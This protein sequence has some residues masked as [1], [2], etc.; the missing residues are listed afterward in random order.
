M[1][2][3]NLDVLPLVLCL[4]PVLIFSII[5]SADPLIN[6]PVNLPKSLSATLGE[7]R[8]F[9]LHQGIDIKTNA[10]SGYPV[11]AGGRGTVSRLISRDK[12]YGNAIFIDH[13]NGFESVYG[14]LESFE[15]GK[16]RLNTL[17]KTLK[18]IYNIDD[19]DFKLTHSN[20]YFNKDEKIAL[21][22]ESGSGLPHLHFEIRK[23]NIFVNPLDYIHIKDTTP[24]VIE[25][26][27]VCVEKD[28]ATMLETN[29]K[30]KKKKMGRIHNSQ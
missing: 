2:K 29:I 14:H 18:V 26:I 17:V 9:S 3:I 21:A 8:G 12:G 11:F 4:V 19:L 15:E 1:K 25:N 6:W 28:N 24:P 10:R 7:I 5:I 27:Y 23:N 20:F 30:V 13:G 22:G 16:R